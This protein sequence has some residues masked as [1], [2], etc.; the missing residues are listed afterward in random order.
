MTGAEPN[1]MIDALP[2]GMI[3]ESRDQS[4]AA[5]P[6]R[7]LGTQIG[8]TASARQPAVAQ[9]AAPRAPD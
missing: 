6:V 1:A 3:A 9:P 4:A 2:K 7:K 8:V 5:A